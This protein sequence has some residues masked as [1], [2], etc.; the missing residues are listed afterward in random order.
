M[1]RPSAAFA[2]F[3]ITGGIAA[4]VNVGSRYLLSYA[5]PYA[6]A[7]A[8][9]YLIGMTTAFVLARQFVFGASGRSWMIEYGRFALVNVAAFVQ[10]WVISVGL[11]EVVFPMLRF[12]W[13]AEDV[14]HVIGVASPVVSSY[15]LHKHFSFR[16]RRAV[17]EPI[18]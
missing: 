6:A 16:G 3:V 7:V 13:H 8:V 14:A 5:M 11:A 2:Q 9:A 1:K 12:T 17:D 15:W 10:V 18:A 4:A